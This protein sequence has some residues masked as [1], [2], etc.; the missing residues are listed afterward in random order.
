MSNL[1]LQAHQRT[2]QGTCLTFRPPSLGKMPETSGNLHQ[3]R[4]APGAPGKSLTQNRRISP[5]RHQQRRLRRTGTKT[6][7]QLFPQAGRIDIIQIFN[8]IWSAPFIRLMRLSIPAPAC[9][10]MS[11]RPVI[12]IGDRRNT[13]RRRA[14]AK[15]DPNQE[16][17]KIGWRTNTAPRS[18]PIS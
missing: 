13:S 12:L 18:P 17:C 5:G 4:F 6:R 16:A 15:T 10:S 11:V 9:V 2:G 14:S 3:G 8:V 7:P 1:S